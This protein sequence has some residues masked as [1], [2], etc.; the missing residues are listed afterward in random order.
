MISSGIFL[1]H[2]LSSIWQEV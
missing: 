2:S 1:C